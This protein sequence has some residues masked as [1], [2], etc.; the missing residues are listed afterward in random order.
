MRLHLDP[1]APYP[2]ELLRDEA[3]A[4]SVRDEIKRFRESQR[5]HLVP[6][7]DEPSEAA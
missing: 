5:L 3:K 4:Q 1:H 6:Q 2:H 7:A